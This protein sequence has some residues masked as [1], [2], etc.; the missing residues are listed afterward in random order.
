[1]NKS[2]TQKTPKSKALA[3]SVGSLPCRFKDAGDFTIRDAMRYSVMKCKDFDK[4]DE[5][6]RLGYRLKHL[7]SENII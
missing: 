1:M 3:S 6:Q 7:I 2:N 4:S 5:I